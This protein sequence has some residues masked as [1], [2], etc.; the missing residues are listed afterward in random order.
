MIWLRPEV[1]ACS[2]FFNR[3]PSTNGPFHSERATKLPLALALMPR[4][5]NEFL[6]RLVVAGPLALGRLAPWRHRMAAARRL[7][8][9][10]AVWVVDRVHDDAAHRRTP[11]EP[12][13]APRL[14]DG[15][16]HVVRVGHGT[17][18]GHALGPDEARL[19]RLELEQ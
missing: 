14:A 10:A 13:T 16:V 1:R 19:A 6:R 18:G 3:Y 9:A 4:A 11:A 5:Q 2:A 17:D 15:D 7:A 12:A 8:L